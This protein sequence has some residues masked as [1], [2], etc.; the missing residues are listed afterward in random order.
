LA[1]PSLEALEAHM[2]QTVQMVDRAVEQE[3]TLRHQ[4]LELPDKETAVD[5]LP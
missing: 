4:V 1:L 3:E 2:A 5:L